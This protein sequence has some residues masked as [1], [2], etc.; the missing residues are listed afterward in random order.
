[1]LSCARTLT[2]ALPGP[3]VRVS[4]ALMPASTLRA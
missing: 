1:M 3:S 4:I 2:I